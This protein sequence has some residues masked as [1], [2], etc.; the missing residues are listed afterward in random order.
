MLC[1]LNGRKMQTLGRN[2]DEEKCLRG[3]S[4]I[5]TGDATSE[6]C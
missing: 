5:K 6:D 3:E 4:N 2:E 1:Q